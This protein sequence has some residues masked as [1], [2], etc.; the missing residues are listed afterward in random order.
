MSNPSASFAAIRRLAP[1]FGPYRPTI[2]TAAFLLVI[3]AAIV[4][5]GPY[6]THLAVDRILRPTPQASM[7][8]WL[9]AEP[10]QALLTI[11]GAYAFLLLLTFVLRTFQIRLVSEASQGVLKD[12]RRDAFA[13]PHGMPISMFD[14][15]QVG[16]L[17][18]RLT[19]DVESLGELFTAG[20]VALLS[21][22]A[23]L[24]FLAFVLVVLSPA[25]GIAV[26]LSAALVF[27][28]VRRSKRLQ[29]D[30]EA[31]AATEQLNAYFEERLNG[32][33]TI[34]LNTAEQRTQL[35]FAQLNRDAR[36]AGLRG[37]RAGSRFASILD[38]VVIGLGAGL[39]VLSGT[40]MANQLLTL[41][42][43]VAFVQ[44]GVMA[45]KPLQDLSD[46][47]GLALEA[48]RSCE[49]VFELLDGQAA[50]AEGEGKGSPA[51]D[52]AGKVEFRNVWF[53][54]NGEEWVLSDVSF[55]VKPG[56]VL[57]V[58]GH[59]GAGKTTLIQLLLRFYDPQ[60]GEILIAGTNIKEW[61]REDLRRLF[62]VVLE[63]PHILARS[64]EGNISMG[65]G[66]INLARVE[67]AAR[68][69][70]FHAVVEQLDGGYAHRLSERGE[71]L[72]AG[73]R[74]L[75]SFA[76]A[77]ARK[78]K[79]LLLDEA[80]SNVDSDTEIEIR[81]ALS[82]LV[83]GHTS[84]VIAHRLSTVKRAKRILVLHN[85]AVREVGSHDDLLS[86]RGIYWKLY[87]LQF[88]DQ[89]M[90]ELDPFDLQ[91]RQISGEELPF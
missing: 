40:L 85:G 16:K 81:G 51:K 77:L 78:P 80:T 20:V 12:L 1:Y 21:D 64:I 71:T 26:V 89:E 42:V 36:D 90:D 47:Y 24:Y 50:E 6:L 43:L 56:E 41:G 13:H 8:L 29:P 79:F 72:S 86:K 63:D 37:L 76:R 49:R 67:E 45:F 84:I 57:A 48:N 14:R 3:Q 38:L 23:A 53:A 83:E 54:Y 73:Q 46:H 75:L 31:H 28:V 33:A 66:A 19:N 55:T 39:L 11:A 88:R 60:R 7:T 22:A 10:S 9:P 44:C 30:A 91:M 4:A 65:S 59:T 35:E 82:R 61:K 62:G 27:F 87:Q 5:L 17:A 70:R 32:V 25:L 52:L 74:Q 2:K 15:G 69:A 68:K 58:V 34:Q 18:T